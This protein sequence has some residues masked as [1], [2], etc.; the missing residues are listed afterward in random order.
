M[1][2]IRLTYYKNDGSNIFD[3][4]M[5]LRV[6]K[7]EERCCFFD[8]LLFVIKKSNL[9]GI[10]KFRFSYESQDIHQGVLR[11]IRFYQTILKWKGRDAA[12]AKNIRKNKKWQVIFVSFPNTCTKCKEKSFYHEEM[13]SL[14]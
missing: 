4:I 3:R 14:D 5:I 7:I 13:K 8:F 9:F 10:S 2:I 12:K 1:R 6:D 11:E